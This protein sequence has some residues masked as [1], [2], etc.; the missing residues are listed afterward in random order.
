MITW[1]SWLASPC[2]GGRFL[3]EI[4]IEEG[5]LGDGA[6]Q[7]VEHVLDE[8]AQVDGLDD[9]VAAAGVGQHLAAELGGP[10]GGL[11]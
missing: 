1:D 5:L 7:Q 10:A 3:P 9:E 2:M 8:R 6:L 11:A 4:E